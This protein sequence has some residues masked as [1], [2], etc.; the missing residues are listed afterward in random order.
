ME[1]DY[2]YILGLKKGATLEEI[3]Q[4]Y[5]K[6]S[7]K[8]HPDLNPNDKYFEDR[9]KD[10]QEAYE[11]LSKNT[12]DNTSTSKS[13]NEIIQSDVK[14]AKASNIVAEDTI[15]NSIVIGMAVIF[16]FCGFYAI[17]DLLL[18]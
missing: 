10:I 5:R 8:F 12:K 4:A 1:K 14:F 7:K 18:K 3:K 11:Y 17:Y 6:L 9:F 13:S 15:L 16:V 2:Y